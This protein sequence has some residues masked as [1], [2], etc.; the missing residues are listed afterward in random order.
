MTDLGL[1]F[2]LPGLS[3]EPSDAPFGQRHKNLSLL[4][5]IGKMTGKS[6]QINKKMLH[7]YVLNY[8]FDE[9]TQK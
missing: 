5:E 1:K 9:S 4:V 2:T 6:C 7:F 3:G 8:T